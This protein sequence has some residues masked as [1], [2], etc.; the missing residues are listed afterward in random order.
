MD[1][2]CLSNCK[3]QS[4]GKCTLTEI[5]AQHTAGGSGISSYGRD[6][7]QGSLESSLYARSAAA[8]NDSGCPYFAKKWK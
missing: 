2:N 6:L 7:E 5:P 4:D 8:D 1:I 3:F